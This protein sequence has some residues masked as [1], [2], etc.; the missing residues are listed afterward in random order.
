MRIGTVIVTWNQTGLTLDCLES[1]EAAGVRQTDVW[2]VDNGSAP[3][4]GPEVAGRFPAARLLRLEQNAGFAGGS[5]AGARAALEAGCDALFLLNNDALLAPGTLPALASALAEDPGLAAVSPMVCYA[6][7]PGVIQSVGLAVDPDSGRTSS[8]GEGEIDRGQHSKPAGRTALFGCAMLVRRAA[9]EQVGPFWEPFFSYAEEVD[10]CLRAAR[11]GW[12]LGYAPGP[13]VLHRA[14]RSLDGDSPLRAYLIARNRRYLSR[15]NG[16]HGL[17][18]AL[19]LA[20]ALVADARTFAHYLRR[21]RPANAR[22]LL[23]A[24]W[25]YLLRRTGNR[26]DRELKLQIRNT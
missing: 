7:R 6:D 22:A 10:W 1:L 17:R 20:R 19:G 8:L 2:V 18:G 26:R 5:N 4:A 11:R 21:G 14:S 12:R 23:L 15:R 24:W 3:P 9:W 16:A 25:D 13:P